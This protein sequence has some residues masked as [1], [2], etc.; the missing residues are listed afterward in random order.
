MPIK[1]L[2]ED[3]SYFGPGDDASTNF[4]ILYFENDRVE[5]DFFSQR[6]A[7]YYDVKKIE[8][9]IRLVA[10]NVQFNESGDENKV[11]F[12][13]KFNHSHNFKAGE[14]SCKTANF[15]LT[16]GKESGKNLLKGKATFFDFTNQLCKTEARI[17][18][19]KTTKRNTS[20][21]AN[22][23]QLYETLIDNQKFTTATNDFGTLEFGGDSVLAHMKNTIHVA[24]D[25]G[26]IK[27]RKLYFK[28]NSLKIVFQFECK[29]KLHYTD[30]YFV[31]RFGRSSKCESYEK[32]FILGKAVLDLKYD[33]NSKS[34]YGRV[35][36]YDS[37]TIIKVLNGGQRIKDSKRCRV[38]N[39]LQFYVD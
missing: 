13:F 27:S 38:A 2:N 34:L 10:E 8:N 7:A 5:G 4:P 29:A 39:T 17:Y 28:G 15:K 24:K 20:G 16:L 30:Y 21:P 23:E 6:I 18:L 22:I 37:N 31:K 1:N 3:N 9:G 36:Y 32:D 26:S 14:K 19:H 25:D 33:Y 35:E 11:S 12:T